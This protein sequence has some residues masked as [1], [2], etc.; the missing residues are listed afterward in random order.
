MFSATI[1]PWVS[2]IASKYLKN[3]ERINFIKDED[4][5]TSQ[6]VDHYAIQVRK[7][8]RYETVKQLI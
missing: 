3:M 1:P 8:D 6:T 4:N 2:K 5:R 7:S